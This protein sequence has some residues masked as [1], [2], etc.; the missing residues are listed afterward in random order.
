MTNTMNA[1]NPVASQKDLAAQALRIV[2]EKSTPDMRPEEKD[3]LLELTMMQ[4]LDR[5]VAVPFFGRVGAMGAGHV[6]RI[7]GSYLM[8]D[9]P[10]LP[11]M[12]EKPTLIDYFKKRILL[13]EGGGNHLLQSANLARKNG[14]SDKL[15][16]AC[17]LHDIAV[18]CYIRT[19]HG[20]HGAQLIE[21][22]VDEE[23]A[24]AIRYHQALRFFPDES[25]GYEY[26]ELY[27]RAM[28]EDYVPPDYI[29]RAYDYARNHKFYMSARLVTANDLYAFDPNVTVDIDDFTDI[30]G[31][32][33]KQP[34]EGLGFD[35][36]PTA[37]MWRSI[38]WP[39]NFL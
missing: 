32:T 30:I 4:L 33:F 11:Q 2:S 28:G 1:E 5:N 18:T 36:S 27:R 21:P 17:L 16:L 15:I 23:T 25:V 19:D 9:E 24:F 39:N 34:E 35:D 14:L 8:H 12:P 20:Y 13:K 7:P 29:Q 37:H 26:P 31:R 38:I 10:R 6:N 3:E 22:Y